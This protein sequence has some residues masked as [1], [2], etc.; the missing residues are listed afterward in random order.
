MIGGDASLNV[1]ITGSANTVQAGSGTSA[2]LSG[3]SGGVILSG[4]VAGS[5][6]L[7]VIETGNNNTIVGGANPTTVTATTRLATAVFGGSGSMTFVGGLGTATVMGGSGAVSVTAGSGGVVFNASGL[8][9]ATVDS[10]TGS[11]TIFGAAGTVENL[12]GTMPGSASHPN[13]AVA[14]PGNETVN[15]ANSASS[16]WLSVNTEAASAS[17]TLI[18]GSGADTLIAGS[19][20]GS[21]TMTGGAG[22]DAF[23]FFKQAVGGAHHV[24]S[25]F[26]AADAVYIEGYG[27]GSSGALQAGAT[28]GT[29]G[30]M[31]TLND[32]TTITFSNLTSQTALNGAIQYG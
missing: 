27:A 8:G 16:N 13:F 5:G 18:G 21:V 30:L 1:T 10:G 26:T 32:G 17:T 12:T 19:A 2:I 31:L 9:S 29:G 23:V 3:G 7:V 15:A 24:I 6:S 22:S 4:S 11:V 25:D 28:A 20:P 14:G